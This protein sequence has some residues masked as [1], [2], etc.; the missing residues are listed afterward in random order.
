VLSGGG[1]GGLGLRRL[2]LC[3]AP[4]TRRRRLRCQLSRRVRILFRG[5]DDTGRLRLLQGF[6][7]GEET[8]QEKEEAQCCV[9][10]GGGARAQGRSCERPEKT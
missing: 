10:C 5:L 8:N 2:L 3:T 7:Y 1:G 4:R 9:P 6:E